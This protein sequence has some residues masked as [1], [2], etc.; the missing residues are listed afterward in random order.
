MSARPTTTRA[1]IQTG[2]LGGGV[3]D[4]QRHRLLHAFCEVVA[5]GGLESATVGRVCEQAAVSRRTFYELFADREACLLAAFDD[6]VRRIGAPVERAFRGPGSWRERVRAALAALLEQL[7]A[8]PARA[9][10][11]VVEVAA[12]GPVALARR[13]GVLEVLADAVEE[14][15]GGVR[16]GAEPPP[17]TGQGV[18]GGVLSVIH[19]RLLDRHAATG[20]EA[21]TNGA[22]P[23]SVLDLLGPLT[24]M[25]VHPYLG[26][27]AARR[28]LERPAPAGTQRSPNASTDPFKDLPIR[29]TYRTARVLATIAECPGA[30]NRHIADSAGIV[31]N[32]QASRLLHRLQECGLVE[33]VGGGHVRGGPNAWRLSERGAAIHAAISA[34]AVVA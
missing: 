16:P 17:L 1:S 13:R 3:E 18:V 12:G 21:S 26:A 25:I 32:G 14:G 2:R 10:L 8:D 22:T 23:G 4:M 20:G 31:D 34:D 24:G 11:C 28:E 33:N 27:A 6:A 29:F 7:D 19:T 5:D 30:S 9:R 15:R